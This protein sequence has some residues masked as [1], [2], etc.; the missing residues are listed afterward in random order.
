LAADYLIVRGYKI[1]E[2]NF[3][4][5]LGEIDIIAREG[6][7]LVFIEVRSRHS[8]VGL[9]PAFSVNRRKQR[10]IIQVAQVYLDKHY[11]ADPPCRFDVVLVTVGPPAEV[12]LIPDAFGVE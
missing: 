10:K 11:R 1:I 4:C 2:R 3:I 5:S 6:E 8:A 12:E 9:D 7:D